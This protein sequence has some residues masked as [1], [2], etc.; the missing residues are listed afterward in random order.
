MVGGRPPESEHK[1]KNS[2]VGVAN[3]AYR[4]TVGS[5]IE[6]ENYFCAYRNEEFCIQNC[7]EIVCLIVCDV[8]NFVCIFVWV[9]YAIIVC[10][11]CANFI[12]WLVI[13]CLPIL[14]QIRIAVIL[15]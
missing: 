2:H 15:G 6:T 7:A 12:W 14:I 8:S 10:N 13:G 1:I 4:N 3:H 5:C 11:L 9:L